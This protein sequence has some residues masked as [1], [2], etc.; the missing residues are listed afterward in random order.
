MYD[1]TYQGG[2]SMKKKLWI[3]KFVLN[4]LLGIGGAVFGALFMITG[5]LIFTVEILFQGLEKIYTYLI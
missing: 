5:I 3:K 2:I 1:T 4:I